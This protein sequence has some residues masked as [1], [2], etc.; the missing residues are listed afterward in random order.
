[1]LFRFEL[2]CRL[3]IIDNNVEMGEN[4]NDDAGTY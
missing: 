1:M 4:N 2:G 3:T